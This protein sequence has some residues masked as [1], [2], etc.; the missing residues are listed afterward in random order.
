MYVRMNITGV[1]RFYIQI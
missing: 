1:G